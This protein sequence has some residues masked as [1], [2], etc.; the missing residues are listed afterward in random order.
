MGFLK[1]IISINDFSKENI[2]KVLDTAAELEKNPK[3]YFEGKNLA[4]L[5]FEPSTRTRLSFEAAMQKLGGK[6]LGFAD[7]NVSSHKKGETVQDTIKM[8]DRYADVIVMRHYLDGAA[9]AAS[10][11]SR[12]PVIN[13]G[14]G[15]N[16]H[17]TQTLLDLYSIQKTQK[18]LTKL[19]IGMVGD[20]KHGRTTHSLAQALSL[21]D[22]ELFFVAPK[23]LQMI[24]SIIS[25]LDDNKI[26]YSFHEKIT[27]IIKKVDILYMT[28]IQ[29]ERFS[30]INDYEKVKNVF[31]L[32]KEMLKG[33]KDNLKI[34]HP[35]P[36]VNE[37]STDIDSTKYAYYF[38]QAANGVPIRQALLCLLLGVKK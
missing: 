24:D 35:L 28:R 20:L 37:I 25:Q 8:V 18:K 7:P 29:K 31:V 22:C 1:H 2:F 3:K 13:G 33:A 27:D 4:T 36:R 14:D 5:F 34:M 19:K 26:K 15:A 21:F 9:R 30:D 17:P 23:E 6:I 16:Q 38:E 12:V 32:N 11:V 10:D